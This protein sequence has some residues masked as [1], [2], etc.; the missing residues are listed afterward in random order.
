MQTSIANREQELANIDPSYTSR[1]ADLQRLQQELNS[2]EARVETLY[3]KQGR[4]RQFTSE[5]Q[6]NSFLQSQ[7]DAL[8]EQV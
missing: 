3:G 8:Q 6:R 1:N 5:A 2:A 4:G 7:I